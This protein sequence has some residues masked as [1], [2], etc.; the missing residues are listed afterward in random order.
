[1][2]KE[3]FKQGYIERSEITEEYFDLSKVVKHRLELYEQ[4]LGLLHGDQPDEKVSYNSEWE[5]DA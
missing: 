3:E 2:T 1:M 5:F 4:A